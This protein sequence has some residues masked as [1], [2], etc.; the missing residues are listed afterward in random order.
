MSK[1]SNHNELESGPKYEIED[2][3]FDHFNVA[4]TPVGGGACDI[5][6]AVVSFVLS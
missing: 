3:Q 2:Y 6:H 5:F 4:V 1:P